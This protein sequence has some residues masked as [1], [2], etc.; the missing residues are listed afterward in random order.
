MGVA[1]LDFGTVIPVTGQ[2]GESFLDS[3]PQSATVARSKNNS[4]FFVIILITTLPNTTKTL[5]HHT[6]KF[7]VAA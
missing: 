5:R 6:T 7:S 3:Q 4:F 1:G 2:A